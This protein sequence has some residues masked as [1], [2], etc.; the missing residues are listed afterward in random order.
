MLAMYLILP[1]SMGPGGWINDRIAILASIGILAWFR[2][3]DSRK[4]K[5]TFVVLVTLVSLIN[6]AY[7]TYYCKIL[8]EELDEYTS[9]VQIIE[10]NKTVLPFFFDGFGSSSRVGIFVNAANYYCLDNGGINLGNYEVL[11][12]YFPVKF[13]ESFKPPIEGKEWV[14]A[15]HWQPG[16]IDIC[17]YSDNIDYLVIW[18][19]PDPVTS[20]N[21]R[22]CY[23]LITSNGKLKIFKPVEKTVI[24]KG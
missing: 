15:V 24:T 3:G 9:E 6:I 20:E 13:N 23:S 2:E 18:G 21:I 5:H 22:K 17:E 1:W 14:V 19:E 10:D 12:D 11:F 16:D 8:N 7:I 4:W